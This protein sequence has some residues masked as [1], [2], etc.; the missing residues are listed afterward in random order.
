MRSSDENSFDVIEQRTNRGDLVLLLEG[1]VG[2]L[3]NSFKR[4]TRDNPRGVYVAVHRTREL[5][6]PVYFIEA[7]EIV[8]L[9]PPKQKD[10]FLCPCVLS[11]RGLSENTGPCDIYTGYRAVVDAIT[12]HNGLRPYAGLFVE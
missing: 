11:L 9:S 6:D 3:V 4:V 1:D 2:L 5:E 8:Y 7:G 12:N 10:K